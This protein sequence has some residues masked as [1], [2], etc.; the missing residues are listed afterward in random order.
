MFICMS[1]RIVCGGSFLPESLKKGTIQQLVPGTGDQQQLFTDIIQEKHKQFEEL[2]KERDELLKSKDAFMRKKKEAREEV[3][4]RIAIIEREIAHNQENQTQ[5]RKIAVLKEENQIIKDEERIWEDYVSLLN[6]FIKYFSQYLEDPDFIQFKKEHRITERL[7]YSFEDLVRAHN[8]FV[9]QERFVS[10]LAEQEKNAQAERESRKRAKKI[11]QEEAE[12]YQQAILAG[13]TGQEVAEEIV[14]DFEQ[15]SLLLE[16]TLYEEKREL[17]DLSLKEIDRKIAFINVR[18]FV[19]KMHLAI[20]KQYVRVVKSSTRV[21]EAEIAQAKDELN[22]TKKDYFS[23]K[24]KLQQEWDALAQEQRQRERELETRA[25]QYGI[26][27]GADISLWTRE[28]KHTVASY[29]VIATIGMLNAHV[30]DLQT[31]R[32]FSDAQRSLEDEKFTL[33]DSTARVKETYY[34][35]SE[36]KFGSEDDIAQ[37]IKL[38]ETRKADASAAMAVYKERISSVADALTQQKKALDNIAHWRS[39]VQKQKDVLFKEQLTE[40]TAL[41]DILNHAQES[42]QKRLDILSKLTGIYSTI[43]AELVS[44]I[45]LANFI[46]GELQ[47]ITIWHRP[48]YAITWHGVQ[49]I[50]PDTFSFFASIRSYIVRFDAQV[51][52]HNI[53]K[54]IGWPQGFLVWCLQFLLLLL[55]LY[56]SKRYLPSI[57]VLLFEKGKKS[58]GFIRTTILFLHACT[59]F[60]YRYFT[61]LSIY[62]ICAF[63]A[64]HFLHD[65][66]IRSIFYLASIPYLM[67]LLYR[68]MRFFVLFNARYDYLLLA[69]DFQRRFIIVMSILLHTTIIIFFFRHAFM[70]ITHYRSELPTI[71]LAVNFIIFQTSLIFLITKEQIIQLIPMRTDFWLWVRAQVNTYFYPVLIFLIA[72]IVMNNPYIGFGRLVLYLLSNALYTIILFKILLWMYHTIKNVASSVFFITEE[73]MVRERFA[74]GKSWFGFFVICSFLLCSFLGLILVARIWGW[75][76]ATKDVLNVLYEPIL[77][78]N[79][80]TPISML[81]LFQIIG[82]IIAGLVVAYALNRFVLDKIFDLLVLDAGVQYTTIRLIQYLVILIALFLGFRQVGLGDLIGYLIGALALGIGWYVREPIGDFVAYFIILVQRPIKI[83]DLIRIDEEIT[84]VVRQITPRTVVI[85]RQNSTTIVIPNAHIINRSIINWNYV[86]N[87]ITFPDILITIG[88]KEDPSAVKDL[89]YQVVLSHP[90]VLRNPKPIIRLDLFGEF[91]YIFLIRGY[92]SS[93]YTLDMWDIASDVRLV[94]VRALRERNIEIAVPTRIII[95]K[96]RMKQFEEVPN[97]NVLP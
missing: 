52:V 15:S 59:S 50:I 93:A 72:I 66:Y 91:G 12:K 42:L 79:T 4:N 38:Y 10:Q 45:R 37:E 69:P 74:H 28:P 27:L 31:E 56:L 19:E 86:R 57:N 34:K 48:E 78:E 7:Y 16:T 13:E 75:T 8:L 6:E 68:F 63:L 1:T 18:L 80:T 62:S 55:L 46:I 85:R 83:G 70:S 90:N 40:Y 23:K 14:D 76:I 11:I 95:D 33:L 2:Q 71:F 51:F 36:R 39:R 97:D 3:T 5:N 49:H 47:S 41:L 73:E 77:L 30:L 43:N 81:S 17:N 94:L 24:E 54:N 92:I 60:F 87:F 88:Y 53:Q 44:I 25:Q 32:E 22:K 35:I 58:R 21:G 26:S 9:D 20:F 82:F 84:G 96:M 29:Q 61:Y 67:Y 65:P 89:F 64:L